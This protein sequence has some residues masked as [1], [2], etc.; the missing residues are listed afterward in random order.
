MIC[1][2]LS[3]PRTGLSRCDI[4]FGVFRFVLMKTRLGVAVL[5]VAL[6]AVVFWRLHWRQEEPRRISLEALAQLN[7]NLRSGSADKLLNV[8]VVPQA[9]ANRTRAEQ[10][11]F[12]RK[13]LRDEISPEGIYA[14]RRHG[15]FGPLKDL[16]PKEAAGWASQAGVAPE[17]CVAF[18]MERPSGF[19]AEVVLVKATAL[20]QQSSA[21]PVCRILRCN[22]V[23]QLA[24][25][26]PTTKG[27]Q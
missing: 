27:R 19:R 23:Q 21:K 9:L 6:A 2:L 14:L 10:I 22:N 11:D 17:D 8:L 26:T 15:T 13:V 24:A 20:G 12:I 5:G 1:F 4:E 25:V 18:K 16:F 3:V 7:T